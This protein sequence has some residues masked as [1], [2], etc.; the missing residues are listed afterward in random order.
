VHPS[1]R[2]L[3]IL[4]DVMAPPRPEPFGFSVSQNRVDGEVTIT[5]EAAGRGR[6]TFAIRA[7]NLTVEGGAREVQLSGEPSRVTWKARAKDA[8]APWVAV[9]IADGNVAHRRDVADAR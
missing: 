1:A 6:H 5:V 9:V 7:D 3:A 4:E 8:G 2:W